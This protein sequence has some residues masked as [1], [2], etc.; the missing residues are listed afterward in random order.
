MRLLHKGK[1]HP[2]TLKFRLICLC[3]C[4][5]LTVG[6]F[7]TGTL[8]HAYRDNARKDLIASTEFN[9]HLVAG[10]IDQE[11]SSV[12]DLINRCRSNSS[13]SAYLAD[14]DAPPAETIRLYNQLTADF[15]ASRGFASVHRIIFTNQEHTRVLQFGNDL[16][17]SQPLTLHKLDE[18][19]ALRE[20][21]RYRQWT[22]PVDDLFSNAPNQQFLISA[23]P[24]N[25]EFSTQTVGWLYVEIPTDIILKPLKNYML[26]NGSSLYLTLRDADYRIEG[27]QFIPAALEDSFCPSRQSTQSAS[28]RLY[29]NGD[30]L[31]V[32]CP[33]GSH[34]LGLTQ[35]LPKSLFQLR[36]EPYL[37]QLALL[38]TMALL[39][40]AALQRWL[41]N[42]ISKP[43]ERLRRRIFYMSMGDFQIDPTIEGNDELGEIGRGINDLA[44]STVILM[45]K[46]VADEKRKKDL[47]YQILQSQINP[48]FLYNTLNSIRWMATI[49]NA[50]G[51]AE[52]TTALAR[53]LKSVAKKTDSLV[54]LRE[55][56]SL[57]DD[58]FTIQKYRYGNAMSLFK[59]I[60]ERLLD[61]V[62]P[63]F[64]LQ[65]LLEN[66]IFHGLE[67]AGGTGHLTI[68]V[69][70]DGA[71]RVLI[72]VSDDGVGMDEAAAAALLADTPSKP[73]GLFHKVGLS[74]VHKR[75]R[76]EFGAEY[77]LS[78]NSRIGQYT[79]VTVT[80]PRR[81]YILPEGGS[82]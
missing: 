4:A 3:I 28:T 47:E 34:P 27:A 31:A 23:T 43:V 10:L 57:L 41:S 24:V 18:I 81:D 38:S 17:G 56:L 2:R 5:S 49:Q 37:P 48:H 7:T 70:A 74:N 13:V 59:V 61:N 75:I 12:D 19:P 68:E 72:T 67:P 8:L 51:I 77:G 62:I 1:L 55:E 54:P 79:K 58:Y 22:G 21:E 39:F 6:L 69:S 52:M 50:S 29:E 15:T 9:L 73:N 40:G 66:A 63:H 14:P 16:S 33:A 32:V 26:D 35:T 42:M 11:L 64:T 53:L 82:S 65:P 25:R 78:I 36:L 71:E 30:F 45:D 44:R 20:P 76:Y 60:D 46:R 80:L